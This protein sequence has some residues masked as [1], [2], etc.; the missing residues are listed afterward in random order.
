MRFT[1]KYSFNAFITLKHLL[2]SRFEV[3]K[4][5]LWAYK[6]QKLKKISTQDNWKYTFLKYIGLL[7]FKW[8]YNFQNLFFWMMVLMN[9][10][11]FDDVHFLLYFVFNSG[12]KKLVC[13]MFIIKL[14]M[15]ALYDEV[16]KK[17]HNL[18]PYLFK[19]K[20]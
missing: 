11:L 17:L 19:K 8:G 2:F 4:I 14:L 5:A 7:S 18:N 1:V 9:I 3:N 16:N 12:R 20:T 6:S 10:P 15:L 13:K